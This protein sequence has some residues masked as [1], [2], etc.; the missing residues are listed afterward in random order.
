[1]S[2]ATPVIE[3]EGLRKEYRRIRGRTTIAVDGLDLSVPSGGGVFG[4][5]GPNGAGKTTTVRCLLGL[6]RPSAGQ[7]RLFGVDTQR[8]LASVVGRVGSIVE[9]PALFPGF[10]GRRNLAL[11]GRVVGIGLRRVDEVLELV[12]LAER[13]DDKVRSYSLGMRQR[14][15]MG[16]AL[17]RDPELLV[18]D[19]PV[20]ALDPAGIKETRQLLRRLGDEGRTVFLSSHLLG[21]VQQLC[22]HVTILARGR[23]IAGGPVAEVLERGRAS[24]VLVKV[25]DA[26]RALDVLAQAGYTAE[27]TGTASE[28]ELRVS[29]APARAAGI[30][31]VLA[32]ARLFLHELRP[33]EIDLE[34]VFLEL[35]SEGGA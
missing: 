23:M 1:V 25:A 11:L 13:A 7:L 35:T 21:E 16:A 8:D 18:L 31:E 14:L 5:L 9:T 19:E 15:G 34:T 17:L 20:N 4:F 24:G 28:D 6:V 26:D 12:G 27:R 33:D 2:S 3:V 32:G 10:S 30:T 22:D 29:V